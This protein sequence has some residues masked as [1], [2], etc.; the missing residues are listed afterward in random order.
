MEQRGKPRGGHG[1]IPAYPCGLFHCAD[2]NFPQLAVLVSKLQAPGGFMRLGASGHALGCALGLQKCVQCI[3]A[4]LCSLCIFECIL[5][6][7]KRR[8]HAGAQLVERVQPL[9]CILIQNQSV[10]VRMV[11][12]FLFPCAAAH[13]PSEHIIFKL[14]YLV[15]LCRTQTGFQ[16]A[17][18]IFIAQPA[19]RC[20]QC[21]CNQRQRWFLQQVGFFAHKNRHITPRHC[22]F[23][24]GGVGFAVA[25]CNRKVTPTRTGFTHHPANAR[26]RVHTLGKRR[27][28]VHQRDTLPV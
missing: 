6:R 8:N 19:C 22:H 27:V 28:S 25:G 13:P 24:R 5:Q 16:A 7:H 14:V 1:R 4:F 15:G 21:T 9:L 26:G 12:P 20:F 3:H 10:A 23:Q 17:E 2:Q 18:H 11:F